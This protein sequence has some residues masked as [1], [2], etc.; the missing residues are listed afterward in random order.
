VREGGIKGGW[1]IRL[2]H[3]SII[4]IRTNIGCRTIRARITLEI[5]WGIVY[6]ISGVNAWRAGPEVYIPVSGID[7]QRIRRDIVRAGINAK[8]I[9]PSV[10]P[11][12]VVVY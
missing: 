6:W 12:I 11:Y 7:Q 5:R 10:V 2:S 8:V 3:L 9:S 4:F 1:E